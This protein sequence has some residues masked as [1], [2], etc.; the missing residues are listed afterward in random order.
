MARFEY[1]ISK[2]QR[3]G[4]LFDFSGKWQKAYNII[5]FGRGVHTICLQA[6]NNNN[7]ILITVDGTHT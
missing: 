6:H 5:L 7:T 3:F 1:E 4:V 2:S